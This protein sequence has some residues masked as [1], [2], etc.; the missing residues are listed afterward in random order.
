MSATVV[1]TG[2]TGGIGQATA[3]A[4]LEATPDSCV[5]LVDL[6]ADQVPA[7]LAGRGDRVR[8]FSCD[9]A[10]P[11]SVAAA[12]ASIKAQ[13]PPVD[14]LV[15]GAGTVHNDASLELSLDR[16]HQLFGVHVDG[17]LLWSQAVG[18]DMI[19]SGRGSIVT[20]GSTAALFGHPRRLAYAAAKAAILSM[21]KTL[22]VEWA[23]A[24]VRVNSVVPGYIRTPMIE[25]VARIGL[26]DPSVAAGW[27]ALKRYGEPADVAAAIAYL[28]SDSARY[29]T[30]HSLTVDGGFSV[31]KAE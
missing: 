11:G 28:L 29:I 3:H 13:M 12:Y 6:F 25:E 31:L 30:G 2:G 19:S 9:V 20:V 23:S 4:V 16:L 17:T 1:I 26:I 5:A 15:T 21:T 22:A 8:A 18:Q 24:G 10:D 7:G 27:T 14:G